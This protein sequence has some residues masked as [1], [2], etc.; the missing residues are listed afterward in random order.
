MR[1]SDNYVLQRVENDY[2]AVPV[3]N[4]ADKLCGVIKMNETGGFLWDLL[5]EKEQTTEELMD[6]L[7]SE[8][9]ISK[10]TARID[11]EKVINRLRDI[12]CI[13]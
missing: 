13:E 1:I 2:I 3:G 6:A 8:Y 11:V 12:G 5:S 4:A 10:E 9:G 7:I